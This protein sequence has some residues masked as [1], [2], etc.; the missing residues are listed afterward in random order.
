MVQ[1][2]TN[3]SIF[4]TNYLNNFE[5]EWMKDSLHVSHCFTMQVD[6]SS[7]FSSIYH[8]KLVYTAVTVVPL[9]IGH[10]SSALLTCLNALCDSN[11]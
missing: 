2:L 4:K 5:L 3:Y 11:A 7:R 9:N 10:T 8:F 1:L 6:Q